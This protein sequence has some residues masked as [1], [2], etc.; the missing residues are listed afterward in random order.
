VPIKLTVRKPIYV[1]TVVEYLNI[2]VN[3][4]NDMSRERAAYNYY[5]YYLKEYIDNS[6][7]YI[8]RAIDNGHIGSQIYYENSIKLDIINSNL[9][10][11]QD[12]I[13]KCNGP[14]LSRYKSTG[15][16]KIIPK[17]VICLL[18]PVAKGRSSQ[19]H[20]TALNLVDLLKV[21]Y[22]NI[23][24]SILK[25]KYDLNDFFKIF[26][27]ELGKF[28]KQYPEMEL[29]IYVFGHSNDTGTIISNGDEEGIDLKQLLYNL[30]LNCAGIDVPGD[31]NKKKKGR[32]KGRV[33]V[34]LTN[35]H[36]ARYA[37]KGGNINVVSLCKKGVPFTMQDDDNSINLPLTT[38]VLV[39]FLDQKR[40]WCN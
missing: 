30:D 40:K 18:P 36:S 21:F 38:H 20:Q 37:G 16:S 34:V 9:K 4:V 23:E 39:S 1:T 26:N 17:V 29:I 32:K 25:C 35:C 13:R 7:L 28:K 31:R 33:E 24:P 19:F 3:K 8:N 5:R 22:P 6:K 15:C 2:R 12:I 27:S 10:N 11:L 14:R